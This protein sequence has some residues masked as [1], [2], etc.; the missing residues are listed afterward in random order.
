AAGIPYRDADGRVAD[1]H[2]L[3]HSYITLLERSGASP[4]MAQ[5]L[6]RHSDIRLTMNVY[7]PAR[8]H[9]LV[10]A[11]EGLPALLTPGATA[12]KAALRATG[13]EGASPSRGASSLRTACASGDARCDPV[14]T[15]EQVSA[16]GEGDDRR[17]N[18]LSPQA[19]ESGRERLILIGG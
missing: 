3:R 10:G 12:G 2:A 19:V 4:K 1:F 14:M 11:V 9:D 17:H 5:E 8:L 15:H 18:P 13:T 7:T 6:A 16:H